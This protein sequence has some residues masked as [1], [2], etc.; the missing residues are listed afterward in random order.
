[1][2]LR[3]VWYGMVW[4]GIDLSGSGEGQMGGSCEHGNELLVA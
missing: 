4:Y 2:D 3:M 1:M